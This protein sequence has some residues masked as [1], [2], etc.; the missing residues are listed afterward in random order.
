MKP[1]VRI[2]LNSS[3][4]PRFTDEVKAFHQLA[5][6][7]QQPSNTL[8]PDLM[9][10][11]L[12]DLHAKGVDRTAKIGVA[13][14]SAGAMISTAVC[15]E[16][17]N[18]DFQVS[19]SVLRLK[20][21]HHHFDNNQQILVYGMYDFTRSASSYKEFTDEQY[22]STPAL[23]DWVIKNGFDDGVDMN[24]PRI[25]VLQNTSPDRLPPTLFIVAELDPL[26]DDS[27]GM[28]TLYRQGRMYSYMNCIYLFSA[29]KEILDKAGVKNKLILLKGVLHGFFA[30]PGIYPKVCTQA[31]DAIKEFMTSIS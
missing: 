12:E 16:V 30:L 21:D 24:D 28:N 7:L 10:E 3:R 26:R 11:W 17:K 13:G 1:F 19:V 15:Q 9:R 14:D 8:S 2:S 6:T 5:T 4:D 25:S 23:L 18:I 27:Y 31:V 22:F 29:Y 20:I